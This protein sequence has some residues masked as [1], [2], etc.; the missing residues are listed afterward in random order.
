MTE[1]EF[2]Y[3]IKGE[4][5]ITVK[6]TAEVDGSVIELIKMLNSQTD[7]INVIEVKVVL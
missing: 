2:T 3:E 7:V 5:T 6:E 1:Y 4:E